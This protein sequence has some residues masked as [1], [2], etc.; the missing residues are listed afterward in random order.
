[1]KGWGSRSGEAIRENQRD[2]VIGRKGVGRGWGVGLMWVECEALDW[3]HPVASNPGA[4]LLGMCDVD[5]RVWPVPVYMCVCRS[6]PETRAL[7]FS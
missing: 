2:Y 5:V 1:M 6:G 3:Q 4:W 7:P